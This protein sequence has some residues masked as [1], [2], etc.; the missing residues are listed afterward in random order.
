[1][2][3]FDD[4]DQGRIARQRNN[5]FAAF[6]KAFGTI[7]F[8]VDQNE[9]AMPASKGARVAFAPVLQMAPRTH[10]A[11]LYALASMG[12]ERGLIRR[13]QDALSQDGTEFRIE[14][15]NAP[16]KEPRR[17]RSINCARGSTGRQHHQR[18]R[19]RTLHR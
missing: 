13:P 15:P 7:A 1:M 8:V 12:V 10:F 2:S 17:R 3:I 6:G 11:F 4:L 5:A 14:L 16:A 19:Q 18:S 9:G